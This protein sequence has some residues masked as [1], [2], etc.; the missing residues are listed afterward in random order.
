MGKWRGVSHCVVR[1]MYCWLLTEN[2]TVVSRTTVSKVTNIEYETDE[3]KAR[4]TA[5]DKAIQES[6]NDE[7]HVIAEGGKGEPKDWSEHP[8]DRDTN[9]RRNSVMLSSITRPQRL[10]MTFCQM[11]MM[12]PTSS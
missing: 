11:S 12:K 5:L 1:I 8:F 4:I 10:T 7:A 6:L 3:N 9:L 2:G